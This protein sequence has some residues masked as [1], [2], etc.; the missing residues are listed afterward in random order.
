MRATGMGGLTGFKEPYVSV[1]PRTLDSDAAVVEY[2]LHTPGAVGY[3]G[4]AS[5]RDGVKTLIVR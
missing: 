3:I 1:L 2:G 5:P 4:R